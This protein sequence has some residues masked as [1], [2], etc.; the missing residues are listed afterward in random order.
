MEV[1]LYIQYIS[2]LL[3]MHTT[4]QLFLH[5]PETLWRSSAWKVYWPSAAPAVWFIYV[6]LCSGGGQ[7]QPPRPEPR[8]HS[9]SF[10]PNSLWPWLRTL[11]KSLLLLYLHSDS[12]A[13]VQWGWYGTVSG[14]WKPCHC[15]VSCQQLRR[16]TMAATAPRLTE[17][18]LG[19]ELQSQRY[20]YIAP[21]DTTP[22]RSRESRGGPLVTRCRHSKQN[23]NNRNDCASR[24]Q[25]VWGGI[26]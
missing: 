23:V 2:F 22:L 14:H 17:F 8:L 15:V 25:R 10:I 7:V 16:F 6:M 26:S 18:N 20:N 21:D 4:L 5:L 1:D 3:V 9:G 13:R 12:L 11:A 19:A 24:T